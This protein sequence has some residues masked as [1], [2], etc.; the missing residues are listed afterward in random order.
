MNSRL[1]LIFII[2]NQ[3]DS[4]FTMHRELRLGLN[5]MAIDFQHSSCPD[6]FRFLTT[7]M[8]YTGITSKSFYLTLE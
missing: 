8:R 5:T 1:Y 4:E 2:V 6:S 7:C 3:T